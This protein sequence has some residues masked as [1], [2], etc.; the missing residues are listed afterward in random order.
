M[1]LCEIEGFLNSSGDEGTP[2]Q[3]PLALGAPTA[4]RHH[5]LEAGEP[6]ISTQALEK[7]IFPGRGGFQVDHGE[8]RQKGLHGRRSFVGISGKTEHDVLILVSFQ[9]LEQLWIG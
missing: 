6:G 9:S 5:R 2:V 7:A 1:D 3:F 8:G 4:D